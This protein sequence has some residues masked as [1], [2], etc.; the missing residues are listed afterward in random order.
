MDHIYA[1]SFQVYTP[2]ECSD[3]M[4]YGDSLTIYKVYPWAG[5]LIQ[6]DSAAKLE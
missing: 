2:A 4:S 1:V 6:S 5:H 3:S